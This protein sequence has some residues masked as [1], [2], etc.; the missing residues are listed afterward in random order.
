[1]AAREGARRVGSE[2]SR[3]A[4]SVVTTFSSK[5]LRGRR[6]T[7]DSD[8]GG[9]VGRGV[10]RGGVRAQQGGQQ[11]I[12]S[13]SG[14]AGT[15]SEGGCGDGPGWGQGLGAG[16]E[17]PAEAAARPSLRARLPSLGSRLCGRFEQRSFPD[18]TP[19]T[20]EKS[21]CEWGLET[22]L[23]NGGWGAQGGRRRGG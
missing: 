1:M 9:V 20:T 7:G 12:S 16:T 11:E 22:H 15:G 18:P 23:R 8:V 5:V 21:G 2:M 17:P 10:V 19:T 6:F 13:D 14:G 3:D 4:S